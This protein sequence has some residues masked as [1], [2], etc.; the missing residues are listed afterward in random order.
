MNI[1][2]EKNILLDKIINTNMYITSYPDTRDT[3]YFVEL[4][5]ELRESINIA[6]DMNIFNILLHTIECIVN[7]TN[8]YIKC[9]DPSEIDDI[10]FLYQIIYGLNYTITYINKY[11]DYIN[12]LDITY[13]IDITEDSQNIDIDNIDDKID[14]I[15]NVF[16]SINI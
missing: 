1:Y 3:T 7:D 9:I 15:T 10:E 11:I 12:S 4:L 16:N 5:S 13:D 6:E 2:I 8:E 14:N